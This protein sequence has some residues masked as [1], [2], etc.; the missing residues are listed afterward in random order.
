M[1]AETAEALDADMVIV[2]SHGRSALARAVLGS[3]SL[4]LVSSS[5]TV[6]VTVVR[7][8]PT[9]ASVAAGDK[10]PGGVG[11]LHGAHLGSGQILRDLTGPGADRVP[12]AEVALG[13]PHNPGEQ[14]A[15][16]VAELVPNSRRP[17]KVCSPRAPM[18]SA[19]KRRVVA[20]R[21]LERAHRLG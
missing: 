16:F 20:R 10:V 7:A 11:A 13:R 6:P 9:P 19:S 4:G 1:I 12:V 2:G 18:R 17:A 5:C 3:V 14:S 8:V 21:R 15:R